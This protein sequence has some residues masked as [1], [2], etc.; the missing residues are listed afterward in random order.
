[1]NWL[2]CFNLVLVMSLCARPCR[3]LCSN[4]YTWIALTPP[5][6]M[7]I[8]NL[9]TQYGDAELDFVDAAIVTL[10]ERYHVRQILTVDRRDF[11]IIRPQHCAYFEILP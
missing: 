10:A 3:S 9:L 6:L 11:L 2:T 8:N 1:M 7:R 5:D 4:H